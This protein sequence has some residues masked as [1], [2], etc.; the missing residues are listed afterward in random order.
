MASYSVVSYSNPGNVRPNEKGVDLTIP[1]G[2]G[3]KLNFT[4]WLAFEYQFMYNFTNRDTRDGKVAAKND[5]F[6]SNS[7]ALIFSFGAPK[8]TDKDGVS[9]KNDKCSNTPAGVAVTPDGCPIDSDKDGVADYLDKCP[10]T[11]IGVKVNANGCPLDSDGDGIS[12]D[13]DK[14]PNTPQGVMVS[15]DGCPVDTDGDGVPDYLDKCPT[16]AGIAENKGCPPVKAA[17]IKV[18]DKALRGIHFE[19]AKAVIK[20]ESFQILNDI[21]VIMNEDPEY[22]LEINGHT[23]AVGTAEYNQD[24]SQRRA[25]AVVKY[26]TDKGIDPKRMTAKGFGEAVPVADNDTPDGR[27]LNI[28]VEFKVVF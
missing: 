5:A 14:C 13:I 23:D 28:R 11:P 17:A 16:V 24:L 15:A 4:K 12:D 3:I 25:Y 20:G 19:T 1:V 7:V 6:A 9:D 18:F 8:D 21:V 2:L 10:N 26:L 27:A 22:N